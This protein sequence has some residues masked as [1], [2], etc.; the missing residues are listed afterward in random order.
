MK[1]VC[2]PFEG[3]AVLQPRRFEDSRGFFLETFEE[4]RYREVGITE[5]FVQDN[6]SRSAKN[7]L[8]GLHFTKTRPQAQLVT[9]IRGRIFDVVVDV[10]PKSPTFGKWFGIELSDDGPMQIYMAYGFA[11]GFYVLSDYADVHYKVSQRYDP[12]DER[13]IVWNDPAI[14]I[15]WQCA[16]PNVSERD[17]KYPGLNDHFE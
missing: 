15:N 12:L 9:V 4:T 16:A 2:R 13:G 1:V 14:G 3:V 6:H 7:V 5:S 17:S 8:R 11:H 10:R